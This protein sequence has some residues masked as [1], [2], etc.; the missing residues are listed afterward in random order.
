MPA[1]L[2][3][4]LPSIVTP[5]NILPDQ[6][7]DSQRKHHLFISVYTLHIR[8]F[9]KLQRR[10]FLTLLLEVSFSLAEKSSE[11]P[12]SVFERKSFGLTLA[13]A[14]NNIMTVPQL[15]I[16]LLLASLTGQWTKSTIITLFL[17]SLKTNTQI[18]HSPKKKKGGT[19]QINLKYTIPF[20]GD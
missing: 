3:L 11:K 20:I 18:Y 19:V 16:L 7:S 9:W 15:Q 17:G 14:I 10:L 12:L 2:S 8:F 5:I 1:S 4:S 13:T 6:F